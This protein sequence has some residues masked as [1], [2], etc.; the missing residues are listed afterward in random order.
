MIFFRMC[1]IKIY[2]L[3]RIWF[4]F[5]PHLLLSH[6]L[7]RSFFIAFIRWRFM[8]KWIK[9][10]AQ[11]G[12]FVNIFFIFILIL[13]TL[14]KSL[15]NNIQTECWRKKSVEAKEREREKLMKKRFRVQ[16]ANAAY[17]YGDELV[18]TRIPQPICPEIKK[19]KLVSIVRFFPSSSSFISMCVNLYQSRIN[20]GNLSCVRISAELKA[21][22]VTRNKWLAEKKNV[23]PLKIMKPISQSRSEHFFFHFF[24]FS[25]Y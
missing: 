11:H 6:T 23:C 15:I 22:H 25:I 4:V 19:S 24:S 3:Y 5:F 14:S 13:F 20:S 18:A 2:F 1:L 21:S 9:N 7:A 8:W 10:I 12:V 16:S 17:L